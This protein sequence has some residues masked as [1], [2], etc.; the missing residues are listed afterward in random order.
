MVTGESGF[1][2]SHLVPMLLSQGHEVYSLHR[3]VS[4][5]PVTSEANIVYGDIK[6]SVFLNKELP[7]I[8]PTVIIHLAGLTPVSLSHEQPIEYTET[9]YV[10][11][12]NL[13][14]ASMKCSNLKMFLYNTTSECYG[15]QEPEDIPIQEMAE[16]KP[17]TPYA[18]C[19]TPKSKI[20][21]TDGI[22]NAEEVGIQEKLL[23]NHSSIK[24]S[25]NTKI[26]YDGN[27]VKIKPQYLPSIEVTEEHPILI[28]EARKGGKRGDKRCFIS[29]E[30]WV[31]AGEITSSNTSKYWKMVGVPKI[32][33]EVPYNISLEYE[34]AGRK[35]GNVKRRIVKTQIIKL[36][37]KLAYLLGWFVAEGSTLTNKGTVYF[38]LGKKEMNFVEEICR[39]IKSIF[40]KSANIRELDTEL[41]I[42][43]YCSPF[44]R[45]LEQNFGKYAKNKTIPYWLLMERKSIISAFLKGLK[46][47]DGDENRGYAGTSE[48]LARLV[49]ILYFK[50]GIITTY[51]ET[52]SKHQTPTLPRYYKKET[53]L[54]AVG[55]SQSKKYKLYLED[56]KHFWIPIR[57]TTKYKYRGNVYPMSCENHMIPFP[58]VTHNSKAASEMYFKYYLG[59]AYNFPYFLFCPFNSFG[60]KNSTHFVIESVITKMLKDKNKI[61]VG[62]LKPIR[63]FVYIDDVMKAYDVVINGTENPFTGAEY[64][65]TNT[66]M[67]VCTGRGISIM[68]LVGLIAEQL[69]WHGEII[70]KSTY[71]RPTEIPVLIGN[72]GYADMT[73]GWR[74]ETELEDGIKLTINYWREK[75]NE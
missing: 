47:G 56:E 30:K 44:S 75:Y 40:G 34:R 3:H 45:F 58:F 19:F 57:K 61:H 55:I 60:R 13:A 69:D 17:N 35:S 18:V 9:N 53:K 8:N 32:T 10:G 22:K 11:T 52:I 6:D 43:L 42:E 31:R 74:P 66:K 41:R 1:M 65:N 20:Y 29:S 27:I 48:Q 68:E 5:R 46:L 21:L 70:A 37:P 54:Y 14:H 71:Q 38:S 49:Q 24:I 67:N 26:I 36:S 72:N 12:L 64:I 50:L 63:D 59:P 2:G 62:D 39:I 15:I 28:R 7:M 16:L 4:N 25:D 51:Y 73:W 33:E 23:S